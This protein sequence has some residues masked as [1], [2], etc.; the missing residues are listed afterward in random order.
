[1]GADI[2]TKFRSRNITPRPG[3]VIKGR[4]NANNADK[5]FINVCAHSVVGRPQNAQGKEVDDNHLHSR[6]LE[7]LRVPQFAGVPRKVEGLGMVVDVL[8]DPSV[9]SRATEEAIAENT[10]YYRNRLTEL[11]VPFVHQET[12]GG[13]SMNVHTIQILQNC[14]Y[15]GG[16]GERGGEPIPIALEIPEEEEPVRPLIQEVITRYRW[17]TPYKRRLHNIDSAR[18]QE[19]S[20][21][22]ARHYTYDLAGCHTHTNT[23]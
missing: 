22:L 5:I 12:R 4:S 17:H 2:M 11:A 1:M 20:H 15:K 21:D 18:T 9:V 3:Y 7:S 23:I 8:F 16:T 13:V 6:G 19:C 10:E 14:R